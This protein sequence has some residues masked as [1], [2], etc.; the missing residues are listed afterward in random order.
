MYDAGGSA[1][2]HAFGG[3]FGLA[4]SFVLGRSLI[5][6]KQPHTTYISNI[7][8]LIGT[9]FLWLFWPSFNAGFFAVTAQ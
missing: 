1:T 4:V 9:F 6:V 3:Y 5:S 8:A 7:F 2:I